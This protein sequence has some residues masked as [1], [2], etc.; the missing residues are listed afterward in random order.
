MTKHRRHWVVVRVGS[1]LVV[2][3]VL[4]DDRFISIHLDIKRMSADMVRAVK[5]EELLSILT[6]HIIPE[7][8][9]TGALL[10]QPCTVLINYC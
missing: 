1:W 2:E 7:T 9:V 10:I 8:F 3:V 4:T 5:L 6:W